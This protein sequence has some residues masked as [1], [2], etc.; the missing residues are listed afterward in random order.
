[1]NIHKN[2]FSKFVKKKY[3]KTCWYCQTVPFFT[4]KTPYII[5]V[6]MRF[7]PYKSKKQI[8]EDEKTP[9]QQKSWIV[10]L[11]HFSD[12]LGHKTSELIGFEKDVMINQRKVIKQNV[13]EINFRWSDTPWSIHARDREE[14]RILTN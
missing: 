4:K 3:T 8:S 12:W 14:V 6:K 2:V 10:L 7:T 13:P 1:M 5:K 9:N 11:K